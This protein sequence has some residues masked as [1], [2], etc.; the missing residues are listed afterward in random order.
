M[1]DPEPTPRKWRHAAPATGNA[2][3]E[4]RIDEI[5]TFV[6][7][8]RADILAKLESMPEKG[9]GEQHEIGYVPPDEEEI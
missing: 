6:N 8:I 1:R 3:R 7:T 9:E 4:K 5:D 2:A